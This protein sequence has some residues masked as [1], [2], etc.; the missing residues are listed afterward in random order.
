M[1]STG[2]PARVS[3]RSCTRFL[4]HVGA[5]PAGYA[6]R[7]KRDPPPRHLPASGLRELDGSGMRVRRGSWPAVDDPGP[8]RRLA[9]ALE[10]FDTA[11]EML[12]LRVLRERPDIDPAELEAVLLRWASA[13]RE[14]GPHL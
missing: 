11:R 8:A 7:V 9:L 1:V 14:D 10:L 2:G 12:R 3:W 13:D 5:A 6:G 4:Q